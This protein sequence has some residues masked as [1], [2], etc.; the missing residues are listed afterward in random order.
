MAVA[1]LIR[2]DAIT[3]GQGVGTASDRRASIQITRRRGRDLTS[4]RLRTTILTR[5]VFYQRRGFRITEV[6]PRAVDDAR[7]R[8]KNRRSRS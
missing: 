5:C 7:S 2:L 1:E 6:R 8:F 3:A 4:K